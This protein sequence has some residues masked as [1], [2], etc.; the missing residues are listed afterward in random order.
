[1]IV[2]DAHNFASRLSRDMEQIQRERQ[3][4]IEKLSS[5]VKVEKSTDDAGALSTKIKQA[6]ELKRLRTV[7]SNLQNAKSYLE[8]RDGALAS[9]HKIYERMTQLSTMA[10]DITKNDSDRENYEKEFQ[11]LRDTA[12]KISREKF[13]GINL[14]RDKSYTLVN[15]NGAINWTDSKAE[16]DAMNAS[17]SQSDHYLA[18]ITSELEQAEIAFQIGEVGINAWLGGNDATS[19]GDWRWTEG[20]E[21]EANGGIGTPFWS[22]NHTTGNLVNG[23]FENW[24]NNEPNNHPWKDPVN[25]EDYLQI[26]QGSTPIGSWNDL[27]NVNGPTGGLQPT[28]YVRETDQGNLIVND[29]VEGGGFEIGNALFQKFILNSMISIDSIENAKKALGTLENVLTG[30]SNA[31]AIGGASLSRLE[32]EITANENLSMETEKSL[33]RIEDV[34]MAI[35]ASRLARAEIKMQSTTAIFAQANKLFNQRNYVDE[36]LS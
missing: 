18:T 19:E 21:G 11:E 8:V 35:T 31:R 23:M 24:G 17:D 9:V 32:K 26:S 25:G 13:N 22:G 27:P 3:M 4:H 20:P 2:S 28:G 33:S 16:V 12:L 10:M 29:D 14:F 30:V 1:M 15:K 36:L 5:G 6:S 7:N 34:D